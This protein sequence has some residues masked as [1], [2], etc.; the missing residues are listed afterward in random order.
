MERN[1]IAIVGIHGSGKSRLAKNI[2]Q[3]LQP[4]QS[5]DHLA[6]GDTIRKI[7]RGVIESCRSEEIRSHLN[8]LH[9][10]R[11]IDDEI[12]YDVMSEA[13]SAY[14][15]SDTILIDGFP[16]TKVQAEQL[17]TL[18]ILNSCKVAGFIRTDTTD[19]DATMRMIKRSPR[20]YEGS[21]TVTAARE[22]IDEDR[23]LYSD[24]NLSLHYPDLPLEVIDTSGSKEDSTQ[25]G[26]HIVKTMLRKPNTP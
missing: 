10:Q 1:V 26:L 9:A 2:V 4:T 11:L 5:I 18:A 22:R 6:V 14:R 16:R 8:S 7:G 20:D 3:E 25:A 19:M 15:G 23:E 12:I 21:L 13:F 17:D 24:M